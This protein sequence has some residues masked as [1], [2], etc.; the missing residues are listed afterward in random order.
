MM[1][2]DAPEAGIAIVDH[3][4]ITLLRSF[5]RGPQLSSEAGGGDE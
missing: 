5:G 3:E 4:I 1:E 2:M